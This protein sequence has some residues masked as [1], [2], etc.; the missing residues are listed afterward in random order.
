MKRRVLLG[1]VPLAVT[2]TGC[3]DSAQLDDSAEDDLDDHGSS[4]DAG[5]QEARIEEISVLGTAD[6]IS[7][8]ATP[9]REYEYLE[10]KDEVRIEYDDPPDREMPFDEWGRRRATAA[11][12]D[13][14]RSVLSDEGISDAGSSIGTVRKQDVDEDKSSQDPDP[15]IFDREVGIGISVEITYYYEGDEL[16]E[17]PDT[18]LDTL[19]EVVPPYIEVTMLFEERE[20]TAD[21]P[22]LCTR[23]WTD[24]ER[25]DD[26]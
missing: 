7:V 11:G 6:P 10:E 1:S 19:V 14:I 18:D 21:V 9:E 5:G 20:Y 8:E 26:V 16:V 22:I 23:R 25:M 17:E 3:L 24:R 15:S 12:D 13:K 2:T 4:D